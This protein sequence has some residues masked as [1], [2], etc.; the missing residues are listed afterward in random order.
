MPFIHPS[1]FQVMKR[2][3]EQRENVL[4]LFNEDK[5]FQ[6]ICEDYK[7]CG[8]ALLHWNQLDSDEAEKRRTEYREL[9]GSL[10]SEILLYL[11]S[12]IPG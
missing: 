8:E 7:K 4:H 10:E 11:E 9:Q 12:A 5:T 6:S 1:I 2:F 3:P